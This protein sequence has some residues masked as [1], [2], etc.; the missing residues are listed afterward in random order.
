MTYTERKKK[1]E[2]LL[3]LIK[4]QRLTSLEETAHNLGCSE[5]TVRRMIND[6]R[7]EGH[8]IIFCRKNNK[9]LIKK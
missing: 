9:Y 7:G 6:L 1:E 2:Y 4:Q 3:Y 5:R 8:Q